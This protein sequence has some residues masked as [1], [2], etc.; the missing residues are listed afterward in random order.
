MGV[1]WSDIL[2]GTAGGI[3]GF[4]MATRLELGEVG[5][6]ASLGVG[7][8]VGSALSD[9]ILF[10][11]DAPHDIDESSRETESRLKGGP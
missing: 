3:L 5:E 1:R 4:E 2:A 8:M 11:D 6:L 7:A 9:H 10:P